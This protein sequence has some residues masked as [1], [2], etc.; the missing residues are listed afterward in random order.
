MKY[1]TESLMISAQG[2]S[3]PQLKEYQLHAIANREQKT[4]S[5]QL[6][7]SE[8]CIIIRETIHKTILM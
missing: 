7:K 1:I 5:K 3:K 8:Q 2:V 4:R 6:V